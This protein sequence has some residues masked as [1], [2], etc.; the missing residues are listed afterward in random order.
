MERTGDP[1]DKINKS[2]VKTGRIA[3]WG[4]I[5]SILRNITLLLLSTH[6]VSFGSS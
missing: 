6:I 2:T 3:H 4:I 5:S 1:G